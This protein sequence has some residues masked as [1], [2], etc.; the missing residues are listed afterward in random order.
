MGKFIPTKAQ[1][2]EAATTAKELGLGKLYI[3][4][5]GHYFTE[6]NRALLNVGN[7]KDDVAE[8]SFELDNEAPVSPELK[9]ANLVLGKTTKAF[10]TATA[11]KLAAVD[12]LAKSPED[13]KLQA[14]CESADEALKTAEAEHEDALAEVDALTETGAE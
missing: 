11:K 9:A 12:K 7:V 13:K 14:A 3:T 4:K 6:Q 1:K 10:E 8:F 2:D 5:D